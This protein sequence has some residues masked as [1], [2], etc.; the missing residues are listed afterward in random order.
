MDFDEYKPEVKQEIKHRI[1][2][3]LLPIISEYK[4]LIV[5]VAQAVDTE[6]KG[7][8]EDKVDEKIESLIAEVRNRLAEEG[9]EVKMAF[10]LAEDDL[11]TLDFDQNTQKWILKI[12]PGMTPQIGVT[13]K[14]YLAQLINF[15]L[16]KNQLNDTSPTHVR[17]E[18]S[19]LILGRRDETDPV[20]LVD[21][22]RQIMALLTKH[23]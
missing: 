22:Y 3:E 12:S 19:K 1:E 9:C 10:S 17:Q 6:N 23:K 16:L 15:K 14:E 18:Q 21:V 5:A 4:D 11:G 13:L 2:A 8:A 20:T 7:V